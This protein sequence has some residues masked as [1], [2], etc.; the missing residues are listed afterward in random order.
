MVKENPELTSAVVLKG[1]GEGN[2]VTLDFG[3]LL[4]LYLLIFLAAVAVSV[5]AAVWP[6]LAIQMPSIVVMFRPWRWA[7][8]AV[9]CLLP[10]LLLSLQSMWGFSLEQKVH[11]AVDEKVKPLVEKAQKPKP[12]NEEQKMIDM[13]RA[14]ILGAQ[15]LQRTVWFRMTF[16]L[17][18]LAVVAA[19]LTFW[20]EWRV[21]KE[22]QVPRL[23]VRW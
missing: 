9:V 18:I 15:Q 2:P 5:F 19:A 7:L 1:D 3:F 10:F 12:S 16:F 17:H 21:S 22:K 23:D 8:A 20:I 13:A 14:S 11:A 6:L 4:W